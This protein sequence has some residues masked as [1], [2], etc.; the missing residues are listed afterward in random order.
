MDTVG[1]V[2]VWQVAERVEE[3]GMFVLEQVTEGEAMGRKIL[4]QT[5]NTV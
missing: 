4:K 5:R 3:P 2:C 1:R